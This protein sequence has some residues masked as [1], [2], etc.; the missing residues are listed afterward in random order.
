MYNTRTLQTSKVH[1]GKPVDALGWYG[2][3]SCEEMRRGMRIG[4]LQPLSE[5]FNAW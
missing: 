3:I 2:T 5:G 4:M 1:R